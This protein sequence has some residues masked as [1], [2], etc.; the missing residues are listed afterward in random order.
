MALKTK[1]KESPQ[2]CRVNFSYSAQDAGAVFLVGDFNQWNESSHP[3]KKDGTGVW[4]KTV[5]LAPGVYEYK[6]VV[7]GQW[8][9]DPG[10]QD[11]CENTF[12]TTNSRIRVD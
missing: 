1:K 10:N 7:D 8:Q 9:N 6:F 4:K 5:M 11:C 3:M 12:G 2:K